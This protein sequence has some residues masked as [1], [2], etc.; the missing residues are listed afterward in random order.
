MT[1]ANQTG[2]AGAPGSADMAEIERLFAGA[3][4]ALTDDIVNRMS[5]TVAGG[6]DLLDR[7]NR[8]GIARALPIITRMVENGDLERLVGFVRLVAA[9]E[10]SLSDD[11]VNRL[12]TVAT[13]LAALVDKLARN[14]GFLRLIDVLGREE[15]QCGLIDLAE[16]ACAAKGELA[17]M[18]PP[19]GGMFGLLRTAAD[20]NVQS[21]LRFV[22]LVATQMRNRQQVK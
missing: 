2:A 18:P 6:L 16:S 5:G 20:P 9:I 4:D 17:K 19:G 12:A 7:V 22:S 14:P 10:D 15:V 11:I 3:R 8:S 1:V 21:A 13:E